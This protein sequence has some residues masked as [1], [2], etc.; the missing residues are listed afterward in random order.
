MRLM[1]FIHLLGKWMVIYSSVLLP[2][3]AISAVYA[4]GELKY[5]LLAFAVSVAIGGS[6]WL[7]GDRHP[8]QL[9]MRDGFI[10]VVA[11]WV[12]TSLI[13]SLHLVFSLGL[14]LTDAFFEV[15]SALT[16]T[17]ATVL[18]GLDHMPQSVLFFRQELQWLG[19]IGV[20]V[21]AV[22]LLPML[23]IG[24]MQLFKAETPGPF[25][26]EKLTPRISHTAAVLWKVYLA[27]TVGCA[28]GYWFAGMSLFDAVAHSF[29]TVSTGGFSTHDASFAY[30]NNPVI[31]WV[32]IVFMM[33]GAS[34]FGVHWMAWRNLSIEDYWHNEETRAFL[35]IV[36]VIVA[37]VAVELYL[38]S[39]HD[40]VAGAI[41]YSA[42]TVVSVITSTGFGTDSF[43]TWP[44]FLPLFLILISFI[45]GCGGSTAGG[46][47]V[48]RI[49]ILGKAIRLELFR[50]V[51]PL[52]V[53]PLKLHGRSIETRAVD[54]VMGFVSV[55]ILI[56][57]LFVLLMLSLGMNLESAFSAVA[58]CINN[59]GPAL[60]DVAGNFQAV[61]APSKW[62][63]AI[64]MLLG[65]LEIFTFLVLL[66]PNFWRD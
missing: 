63:L 59:L 45:G 29:S 47:K 60:G 4:D 21:S 18:T 39:S 50:L 37:I 62:A 58:T 17:G 54:G 51:H 40:T 36:L 34:S 6:L 65:R 27:M 42:F 57:A 41:R 11:L 35:L 2:P 15:V 8:L 32:S 61:S 1:M 19:G 31:D 38:H 53:K 66:S 9:K 44:S 64:V 52:G 25:K 56:F 26:E 49:V 46:M 10:V 16:T 55:Y 3:I 22:A 48:M 33:I 43:A 5:F 24:G 30:F 28:L 12:A 14:S 7:V 20:V 13:G 23:G